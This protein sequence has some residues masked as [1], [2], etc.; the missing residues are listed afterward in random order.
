[1]SQPNL[2]VSIANYRDSETPYTVADLLAQ[3]AQPRRLTVGVLS[4]VMPGVEEDCLAPWHARVR[5]LCVQASQSLGACWARSRILSELRG[6][7]DYVL[8]IDSH[9]RFAPGWDE[10]F[11]AM[12]QQCPS[13]K[14]VLTCHPIPYVPP[15]QLAEPAVP[16]LRA[17]GFNE[18][19]ILAVHS[20]SIPWE[21]RPNA[22]VPSPFVGGGCMFAPA[23]AFD[24]VPYD[25]YLYFQGEEST[26]SARLWTHGWDFFAPNDVLLYH[27]YTHDRGRPKH[28]RDNR[29]WVGMNNRSFQRVRYLLA[30]EPPQDPEALRDIDRYGLGTTRSRLDF[31]LMAGVD[32]KAAQLR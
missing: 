25:P 12:L 4:Q 2:F 24:E 26:L 20:R 27:D 9:T 18:Q 16:V 17:K 5:Q 1:M 23:A 32:F 14:P 10:R 7:E 6:H 21:K 31:E 28:W 11:I 8:Q 29:D 30:G 22:P 19:G 15:R 13:N 3:A